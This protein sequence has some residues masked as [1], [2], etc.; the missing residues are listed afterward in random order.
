[1][2]LIVVE[3]IEREVALFEAISNEFF[4]GKD[5]VVTLLVP[6]DMNIYMLYSLL[7]EDDFE[8]DIIELLKEHSA[9]AKEK[10]KDY[11]RDS[12]SEVY[13]FFDFDEHGNN[14]ADKAGISN[15]EA[16]LQ[17]LQVFDNETENGK[18]YISYP[19]V[20]AL[21]DVTL[22]SCLPAA[23]NCFCNRADFVN[24]KCLTASSPYNNI[25]KYDYS[26]WSG[27]SLAFVRRICCLFQEGTMD[28]A[29]YRNMVTP[30]SIFEHIEAIYQDNESVFVLSSIPEFLLDYSERFWNGLIKRRTH[31]GYIS[32]CLAG[33][34]YKTKGHANKIPG[35]KKARSAERK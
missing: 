22:D 16:L 33:R 21:R 8:T 35:R 5:S 31:F 15:E 10:L 29:R 20:E 19:M 32:G 4:A 30:L 12:F 3:G 6:A 14:I 27:I 11:R 17:M 26:T 28:Y 7:K 1:M 9:V 24:Y 2:I 23:G 13:F 25:S 18:L 34:G